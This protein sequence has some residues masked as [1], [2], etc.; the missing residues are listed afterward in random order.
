MSEDDIHNA[1][2]SI[3]LLTEPGLDIVQD[4]RMGRLAFV[5]N[6][7]ELMV[8]PSKSVAEV[9]G[10]DP[11]AIWDNTLQSVTVK[12]KKRFDDAYKHTSPL[13]QHVQ[14][15]PR[16]PQ[17]KDPHQLV[18]YGRMDFRVSNRGEMPL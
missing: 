5:E 2:T 3:R 9:L 4:F 7:L 8:G 1:L 13:G 15:C 6:G 14:D 17:P 11:S 16:D 12:Y 18:E 10:K